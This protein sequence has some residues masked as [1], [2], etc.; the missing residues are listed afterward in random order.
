MSNRI[1]RW[2]AVCDATHTYT[3]KQWRLVERLPDGLWGVCGRSIP[4][5]VA[6]KLNV[7]KY[8]HVKDKGSVYACRRKA[9]ALVG[10]RAED[11]VSLGFRVLGFSGL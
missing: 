3:K 4:R 10:I 6:S 7:T 5:S 11:N 1:K 8:M 2:C 9:D